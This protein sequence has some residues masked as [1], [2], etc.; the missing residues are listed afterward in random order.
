MCSQSPSK[1]LDKLSS[2][3]LCAPPCPPKLPFPCLFP[4]SKQARSVA[5]LALAPRDNA[6]LI[7]SKCL[8]CNRPLGGSTP[9]PLPKASDN[10][11]TGAGGLGASR[12]RVIEA[13]TAGGGSDQGL[14]GDGGGGAGGGGSIGTFKLPGRTQAVVTPGKIIPPAPE[15][16]GRA[17]GAVSSKGLQGPLL[18]E[19]EEGAKGAPS[20]TGL[21]GRV[22]RGG[23][24]TAATDGNVSV[25]KV[26]YSR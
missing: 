23:G 1:D 14:L 13:T 25:S 4:P 5:V 3:Y 21:K 17:G 26:R 22:L 20:A 12:D 16:A 24:A 8:S 6:V 19:R 2:V 18:F 9:P 10:W 7:G 11:Y 15:G